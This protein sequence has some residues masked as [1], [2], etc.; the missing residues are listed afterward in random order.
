MEDIPLPV[1]ALRMD[2][3]EEF[4]GNV[5]TYVFHYIVTAG[6]G[7]WRRMKVKTLHQTRSGSWRPD[8][9]TLT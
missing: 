3:S 7:G 2:K 5:A 9:R 6:P 1:V 8:H 4:S